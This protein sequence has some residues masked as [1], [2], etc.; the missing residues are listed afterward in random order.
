M[1]EEAAGRFAVL[2][3]HGFSRA[4]EASHVRAALQAAEKLD[5]EGGGGFNPRIKPTESMPALAAEGRFPPI[6]PETSSFSAASLAAE[7]M[8]IVKHAFS[9]GLKPSIS[10]ARPAARLKPRPFK[11]EPS[12]VV[13][14]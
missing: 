9:Q 5:P 7:G 8:Q 6:S 14:G 10:F 12:G 1:A 11:A 4:A 2:K 3:G 13:N